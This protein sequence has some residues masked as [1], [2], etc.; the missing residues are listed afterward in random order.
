MGVSKFMKAKLQPMQ[1]VVEVTLDDSS[2]NM[3]L[4]RAELSNHV[5]GSGKRLTQRPFGHSELLLPAASAID[6]LYWT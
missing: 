4:G 1:T 6:E 5:T 2:V 3:T